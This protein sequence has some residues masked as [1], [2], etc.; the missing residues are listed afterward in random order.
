[1]DAIKMTAKILPALTFIFLSPLASASLVNDVI[2]KANNGD[3][4]AQ[5][6]LGY[7]YMNGGYV[8]IDLSKSEQWL[9][10]AERGGSVA[11]Q[12]ML[13]ELYADKLGRIKDGVA[14]YE[15]AIA[16]GNSDAKCTYAT[17]ILRQSGNDVFKKEEWPAE[18]KKAMSL[19]GQAANSGVP[20]CQFI[21]GISVLQN[22]K[23]AAFKSFSAAAKQCHP[24]AMSLLADLYF[25]GDGVLQNFTEAYVFYSVSAALGAT[26]KGNNEKRDLISGRYLEPAELKTAKRKASEIYNDCSVM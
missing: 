6:F 20:H 16:A 26:T 22:D 15:M 19:I 1:M 21:N 13:G 18:Y 3:L 5:E 17:W 7:Q 23:V 4:Y 2:A 14:K 12:A 10:M 8:D 11:A 9:L 24:N 25:R